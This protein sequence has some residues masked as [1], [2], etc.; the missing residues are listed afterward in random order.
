MLFT[1]EFSAIIFGTAKKYTNSECFQLNNGVTWIYVDK[2]TF[3]SIN[4]G[5]SSVFSNLKK[6]YYRKI[7]C[8]FDETGLAAVC[9]REHQQDERPER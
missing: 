5:F 7:D 6:T 2:S 8:R 3:V 1:D 4:H 9:R